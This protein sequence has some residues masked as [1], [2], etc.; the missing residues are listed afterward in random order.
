MKRRELLKTLL[1]TPV[2]PQVLKPLIA[3]QATKEFTLKDFKRMQ[4]LFGENNI[5]I[6]NHFY[7]DYF[8]RMAENQAKHTDE[9][10]L[11]AI[12]G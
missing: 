11:N 8:T 9:I 1:L 3:K 7:E 10:I 6:E 4:A 2:A 5:N 12:A